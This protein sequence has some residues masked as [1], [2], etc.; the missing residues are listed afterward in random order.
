MKASA[1]L[2]QHPS[3]YRPPTWRVGFLNRTGIPVFLIDDE[4]G[5]HTLQFQRHPKNTELNF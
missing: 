5:I 2:T 1:N 3:N 4:K